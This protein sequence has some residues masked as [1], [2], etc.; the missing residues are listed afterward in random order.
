[1]FNRISTNWNYFATPNKFNKT[2]PVIIKTT[3]TIPIALSFSPNNKAEIIADATI[4]TALQVA[5]AA[6]KL[7]EFRHTL[8]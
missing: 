4:P 3:A 1:M 8:H 2:H 7:M 6:P 5:Y